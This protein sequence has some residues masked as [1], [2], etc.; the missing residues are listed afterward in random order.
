MSRFPP[1]LHVLLARQSPTAVIIRRGPSKQVCTIGWNRRRNDFRVG[2]W[3]K[4]RIYERRSDLS[5]DG[6]HLIY[7]AMNGRW[8]SETGGAWTAISR[9][10][11]LKAIGLWGKGD[12]WHGGGLFIDSQR[13]WLNDRFGHRELR[14]PDRL[15]RI[16]G[17]PFQHYFGGECPGVYYL[18]L[19]R[20]G[21]KFVERRTGSI[22]EYVPDPAGKP[23]RFPIPIPPHVDVFEKEAGH[24]WLLWKLA[25]N[26]SDRGEGKGCDYDEHALVRRSSG[27]ILSFPTWEWADCGSDRLMWAE[28]GKLHTAR[29]ESKGLTAVKEL[30][31]CNSMEFE[32]LVAPY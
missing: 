8:K 30:L 26:I 28:R 4:G 31:D 32:P 7:F 16:P 1:R 2:Q 22:P 13:Y 29:L 27:E 24:G 9:A 11:F 15:K 25:H 17:Y 14:A 21:W 19:L 6:R 23:T 12:C 3:L 5:P 10:P 18:R 20:D